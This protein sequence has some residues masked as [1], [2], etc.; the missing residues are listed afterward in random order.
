MTTLLVESAGHSLLLFMVL[1]ALLRLLRVRDMRIRLVA[2]RAVLVAAL[3]MPLLLRTRIV[4]IPV[5]VVMGDML[6]G[7][8][9][10]ADEQSANPILNAVPIIYSLVAAILVFR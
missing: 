6:V 3:F 4:S 2:W 9:N 5:N 7:A 1:W 8:L 10:Y